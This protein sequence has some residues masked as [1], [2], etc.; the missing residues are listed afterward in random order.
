MVYQAALSN[1]ILHSEDGVCEWEIFAVAHNE[2]YLWAMCGARGPIATKG[3]VPAVVYLGENGDIIK[4]AFPGDGINYGKDVRALFPPEIQE[5]IFSQQIEG[6]VD[7]DHV[8]ARLT[9][10]GPPLIVI[11]GT[12]MP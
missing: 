2:V 10:D 4:V 6:Y 8:D 1:A 11:A 5:K 12:P 3:S 7:M 9:A